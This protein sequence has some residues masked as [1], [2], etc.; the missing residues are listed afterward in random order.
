MKNKE[1][2]NWKAALISIL[3]GFSCFLF[4]GSGVL[5]FTFFSGPVSRDVTIFFVFGLSVTIYVA[6]KNYKNDH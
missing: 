1:R 2:L 3:Y 5:P 6:Y 4:F